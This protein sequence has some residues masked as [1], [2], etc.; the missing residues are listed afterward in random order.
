MWKKRNGME[1]LAHVKYIC[2]LH[3][4]AKSHD[5]V[6]TAFIKGCFPLCLQTTLSSCAGVTDTRGAM[7]APL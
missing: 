7:E 2:S 1:I 3:S 5:P 4:C 6:A